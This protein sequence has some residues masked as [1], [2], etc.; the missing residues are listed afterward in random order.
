MISYIEKG[1]M[2]IAADYGQLELRLLAHITKCKSMID[3]FKKGG[4]FHSRTVLGMYPEIAK[5]VEV[6]ESP[7]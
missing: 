1:N 7:L 5:E 6:S 2:L 4:D 3:A